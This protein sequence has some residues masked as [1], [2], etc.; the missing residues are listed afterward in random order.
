MRSSSLFVMLFALII[1]GK[2]KVWVWGGE[3]KGKN[4]GGELGGVL[5]VSDGGW[6][7]V[8]GLFVGFGFDLAWL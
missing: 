8:Y 3:K 5:S 4:N 6:I 1:H 2:E 7:G